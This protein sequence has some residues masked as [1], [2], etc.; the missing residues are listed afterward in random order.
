V[1][2]QVVQRRQ[3]GLLRVAM[4]MIDARWRFKHW[5]VRIPAEGLAVLARHPVTDVRTQVLAH[6]LAFWNWR[7]R[8]ALHATIDIGRRTVGVVNVHL[9][10]GVTPAE[11][12]KQ[13]QA[14]LAACG[15]AVLVGGDLNAG[16]SSDELAVFAAAGWEGAER[17][18]RDPGRPPPSTNW[19]PGPRTAAPTQRLDD[20][21]VGAGTT[22][23]DAYV[24][25]DWE[26]WAALSDHLP[27]VARLAFSV[28]AV[29]SW[30]KWSR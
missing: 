20:L 7:R 29:G 25:T 18:C 4:G 19:V 22:V 9:G 28:S 23:L 8:I 21:L 1:L 10:A 17:R 26:R 16:P 14:L 30:R 15:G 3:L 5:P 13:V 11:R 6:R 24:P 2:L 27:V 12:V